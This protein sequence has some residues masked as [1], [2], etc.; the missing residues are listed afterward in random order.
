MG[1]SERDGGSQD[2]SSRH[3]DPA[4]MVVPLIYGSARLNFP[5]PA[6]GHGGSHVR[7][8]AHRRH[9]A[10]RHRRLGARS[11]SARS[12]AQKKEALRRRRSAWGRQTTDC[13]NVGDAPAANPRCA[14]RRRCTGNRLMALAVIGMRSRPPIHY[15]ARR[16]SVSAALWQ[17]R[18]RPRCTCFPHAGTRPALSAD[19]SLGVSTH[20]LQYRLPTKRNC[21][22]S[23]SVT[24]LGF[25][26]FDLPIALL[27]RRSHSFVG[28]LCLERL[29]RKSISWSYGH[30]QIC[31]RQ[32][33]RHLPA[34][35]SAGPLRR[36]RGSLG[37]Q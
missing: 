9:H 7:C 1:A 15:P 20:G 34:P 32:P 23:P 16:K 18:R 25:M 2:G 21:N 26:R 29:D 27:R 30:G 17:A 31:G 4:H 36:F 33:P 6:D 35:R 12:A 11:C 10:H 24:S 22:Y 8:C 19:P 5:R 14:H 3:Q 13:R 37:N 28:D